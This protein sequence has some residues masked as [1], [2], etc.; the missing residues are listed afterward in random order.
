MFTLNIYANVLVIVIFVMGPTILQGLCSEA[1]KVENYYNSIIKVQSPSRI[2]E[3]TND[4]SFNV[5]KNKSQTKHKRSIWDGCSLKLYTRQ[6]YQGKE[7]KFNESQR[8]VSNRHYPKSI[9]TFG[10]CCW[11]IFWHGRTTRAHFLQGNSEYPSQNLFP[12]LRRV[13]RV[14]LNP[15]RGGMCN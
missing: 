11:R 6:Y 9:K 14:V 2:I 12:V 8:R 3:P 10:K 1:M 4:A 7:V 5:N 13:G 15:K